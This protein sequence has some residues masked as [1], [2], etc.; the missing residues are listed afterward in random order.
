VNPRLSIELWLART[1]WPA[2]AGGLLLL[3]GLAAHL[4][5]LPLQETRI[6]RM[7]TEYRRLIAA[8]RQPPAADSG[9]AADLDAG[10]LL[11]QRQAAFSAVLAPP[12][13]APDLIRTVFGEAQKAGL[14]LAQAEYR[15][16]EDRAGGYAA[17]QMNVPVQGPYLKLREFID[18]VLG[19]LPACA[20]EEVSFKREAIGSPSAE[21]RL[22]LVFYLKSG[23]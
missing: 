6:A 3:A 8:L 20:L 10:A 22:R 1:G 11:A 12:A 18:G 21:A 2:L 4:W 5:W 7:E 13:A 15:R 19:A 16:V 9:A 14:T 17:Y 23:T